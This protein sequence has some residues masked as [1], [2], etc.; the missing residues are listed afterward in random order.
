[1]MENQIPEETK[2]ERFNR[3]K[4][5]FEENIENNNQK[6]VGT[7]QKI[8]VEGYSKNNPQMLTGRTDTNKVVIFTGDK[9]L[10]GNIINVKIL[11]QHKWY[12]KGDVVDGFEKEI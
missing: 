9:K 7:T 10:I 12:L 8:L 3:L 11:S 4:S 2:H 5:L 6:Y 1:M